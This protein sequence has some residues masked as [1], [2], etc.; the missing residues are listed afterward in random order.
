[1]SKSSVEVVREL[2]IEHFPK[3][4]A[5]AWSETLCLAFCLTVEEVAG[6]QASADDDLIDK[7]HEVLVAIGIPREEFYQVERE[8]EAE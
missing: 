1:M 7:V 3:R 6:R 4:K 5:D 8:I 2:W